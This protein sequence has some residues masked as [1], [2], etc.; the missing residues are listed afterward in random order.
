MGFRAKKRIS[1]KEAKR[2]SL[3]ELALQI[4]VEGRVF[5]PEV[6]IYFENRSKNKKK[7]LSQVT[8]EGL[9]NYHEDDYDAYSDFFLDDDAQGLDRALGLA[10]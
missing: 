2:L 8:Q 7:L 3:E 6:K 1:L 9:E 10:F 4:V 5:S